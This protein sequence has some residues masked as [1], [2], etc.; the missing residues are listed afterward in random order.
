MNPY[1]RTRPAERKASSRQGWRRIRAGCRTGAEYCARSRRGHSGRRWAASFRQRRN[2][3]FGD[4]RRGHAGAC[5]PCARHAARRFRHTSC[6]ARSGDRR[7]NVVRLGRA[8]T[9]RARDTDRC[10][11][12]NGG[13]GN[14]T[15][16]GLPG[17][18]RQR[19][20]QHPVAASEQREL[21]TVNSEL[22]GTG[23]RELGTR[24]EQRIAGSEQR[25]AGRRLAT[26]NW[27]LVTGIG[28]QAAGSGKQGAGLATGDWELVGTGN[29]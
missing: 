28:Q 18:R 9:V 17:A 6:G 15:D 29:W 3:S 24:I 26:G 23:N 19:S 8:G 7:A 1:L 20:G 21:A 4:I 27:E 22:A 25:V 13:L 12:D 11:R 5:D 14:R 2:T 10:R 16:P